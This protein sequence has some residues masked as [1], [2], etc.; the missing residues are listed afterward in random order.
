MITESIEANADVGSLRLLDEQGN[1]T[2]EAVVIDDFLNHLDLSALG[3]S[4]ALSEISEIVE[5][6]DGEEHEVLPLDIA[7]ESCDQDD[8]ETM[9]LNYL[10]SLPEDTLADKAVKASLFEHY[11]DLAGL[12]EANKA[13]IK[14]SRAK[15]GKAAKALKAAIGSHGFK[16][17]QLTKMAKQKK[18]TPAQ[19]AAL[20]ML[21][22]MRKKEVIKYDQGVGHQVKDVGYHTGG[23][24]AGKARVAKYK[25][26]Q[27]ITAAEKSSKKEKAP[28][29]KNAKGKVATKTV[30]AV[31]KGKGAEKVKVTKNG[32]KTESDESEL[33]GSIIFG[34]AEPINGLT[35]IAAIAEELDQEVL[36][37]IEEAKKKK[38]GLLKTPSAG[39]APKQPKNCGPGTK[40]E[41][42]QG[43]TGLTEGA[44]LASKAVKQLLG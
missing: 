29:K 4:E 19:T 38:N 11:M 15:S 10:D 22:A 42:Y 34:H 14:A 26:G 32:K 36:D 8:L 33:I 44:R 28:A 27:G 35:H 23:T 37:A 20:R 31:V 43:D 25:Q 9:F 2:P 18:G 24:P 5:D 6:E 12:D 40:N 13:N 16:K 39:P 1:L 7:L 41:D 3:E 17:G 30:K 21:L